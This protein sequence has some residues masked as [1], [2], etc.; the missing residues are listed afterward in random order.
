VSSIA[1]RN[2]CYNTP[3]PQFIPYIKANHGKSLSNVAYLRPQ[4]LRAP[5]VPRPFFGPELEVA[6]E[7][8]PYPL[9][10][11]DI[12][13]YYRR[14]G[15]EFCNLSI[16]SVEILNLLYN[17]DSLTDP[18]QAWPVAEALSERLQ[19]WKLNLPG[20]L[21]PADGVAAVILTLQ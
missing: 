9:A 20:Y 3:C 18:L 13:A 1:S 8:S 10:K 21:A 2:N 11:P 5:E 4:A 19:Q 6:E 15:D 17:P 16:I 14:R 7:W 12:P